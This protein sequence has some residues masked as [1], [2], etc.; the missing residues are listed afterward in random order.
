MAC[1]MDEEPRTEIT[2][3]QRAAPEQGAG[4]LHKLLEAATLSPGVDL[5]SKTGCPDY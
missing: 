4:V 3:S 5:H 2:C 1:V